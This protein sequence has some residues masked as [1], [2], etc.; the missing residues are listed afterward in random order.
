MPWRR[1]GS[2]PSGAKAR[3][4]AGTTRAPRDPAARW[5]TPGRR[6]ARRPVPGQPGRRVP[7][8]AGRPRQ[9][10][11]G[12]RRRSAPGCRRTDPRRDW[13]DHGGSTPIPVRHRPTGRVRAP[14][15][16]G[17]L[18]PEAGFAAEVAVLPIT[19]A[20][21]MTPR[22]VARHLEVPA[23]IDQVILPGYCGGDLGPVL[24]EGPGHAGRT[25]PADL[26]DLPRYFG[27]GDRDRRPTT[28]R[29]R[30]EILA[31]INHAP[32]LP[33]RRIARTRRGVPRRGCRRDRPG[34][35]PRFAMGRA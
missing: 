33:H 12:P 27:R 32:R 18:A 9:R 1:A 6:R 10:R 4:P 3:S 16:P 14:A 2:R 15:G 7:D 31:E 5:G 24:R 25:G 17:R 29:Y 23:G 28:A 26:R 20:A 8:R 35:R 22:W 21:L 34:L 13:N 11:R 19:V 30:I